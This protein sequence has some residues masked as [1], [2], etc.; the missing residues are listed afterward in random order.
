GGSVAAVAATGVLASARAITPP[1]AIK[2]AGKIVYCSDVTY[3]PEEYFKGSKAV[4]SDVDI[5]AAVAKLMGVKSQ[6]KNTTFDSI[7]PAL[8]VKKCDAIISGMNDTAERRKQVDFVDYL[9]VG[10]AIS[11]KKGNPE[12]FTT[13]ASLSGKRVSVE[14]GTTNRDFLATASK[15]LVKQG[16]KPITIVT[17]PKDTDAFAALVAGKVDAY[18]A[19]APPAAYYAKQNPSVVQVC[20]HPINPFPI[21]IAIRKGDPLRSATQKAIAA[22][23]AKGTMKKIVAKWG[24]TNAVVLLK[25]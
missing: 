23:Y 12:H 14:S 18:Y 9:K 24:M 10:Q 21:G 5:A 6:I 2:S 13:F 16:K 20:C 19:D 3:P 1:P 11:V 22:L 17:F 7:I 8:L 15:K 4:G 25:K